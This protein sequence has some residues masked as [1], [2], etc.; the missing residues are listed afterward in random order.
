[1]TLDLLFLTLDV[2]EQKKQQKK[3]KITINKK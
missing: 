3:H 2:N 1:M